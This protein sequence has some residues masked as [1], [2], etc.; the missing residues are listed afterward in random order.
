MLLLLLPMFACRSTGPDH[1]PQEGDR[2]SMLSLMLPETIEIQPFTRIGSFKG[3]AIP[4]GIIAVVQ[5]RDAFGDPVKAVGRFYFELWTYRNAS[6]DRRG[7]RLEFWEQT[8]DSK[9]DVRLH[10]NSAQMYEFQL[11]WTQGAGTVQPGRQ[12]LLTA[13]YRTPW[14][15]TIQDEHV[16][17]FVLPSA[18]L[19]Q[20]AATRPANR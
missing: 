9:D 13:T 2:V 4:E 20:T 3:D 1:V 5:P 14:D 16:L 18:A 12:Y 15:T 17:D 7:E 6:N 19:M 8:L 11:A 10:W